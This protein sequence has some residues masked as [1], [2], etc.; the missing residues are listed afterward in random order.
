MVLISTK[1]QR[2]AEPFAGRNSTPWPSRTR[3]P[4]VDVS[5]CR[6]RAFDCQRSTPTWPDDTSSDADRIGMEK[7]RQKL[8]EREKLQTR[9]GMRPRILDFLQSTRP[10]SDTPWEHS[11][12]RKR[13]PQSRSEMEF[14]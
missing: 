3:S 5:G 1:D 13:Q 12:T 2:R 6:S 14:D 7:L 11:R 8:S 9:S 4:G 10:R